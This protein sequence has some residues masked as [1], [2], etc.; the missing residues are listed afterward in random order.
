MKEASSFYLC[1]VD[2]RA[3][4]FFPAISFNLSPNDQQYEAKLKSGQ[5]VQMSPLNTDTF[6]RAFFSGIEIIVRIK[7]GYV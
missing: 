7:R 3:N 6:V 5:H 1:E 2:E 4:S